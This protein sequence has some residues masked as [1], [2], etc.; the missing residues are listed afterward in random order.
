[1]SYNIFEENEKGSYTP[2]FFLMKLSFPF[3][4]RNLSDLP[5]ENLGTF[6]HEYV[7]YLQNTSTPYGLWQAII[8]YKAI[9]E[10]FSFVQKNKPSELPVKNYSPSDEMKRLYDLENE[11]SGFRGFIDIP[12][13]QTL[14][15]IHD[16]INV[17]QKNIDRITLVFE[18]AHGI[19]QEIILGANIIKESM[20]A[21][22]QE[23]IHPQSQSNHLAMPYHI[24]K[25]IASQISPNIEGDT[26]KL[27]ALCFISL[28]TLN[29]GK[30]LKDYMVYANANQDKDIIAIF[31]HFVENSIVHT[32]KGHDIS[33]NQLSDEIVE[34]YKHVAQIFLFG[35]N[36][37]IK[38]N[39]LAEIV[40]RCKIS[41]GMIPLLRLLTEHDISAELLQSAVE[42]CGTPVI[43]NEFGNISI[44][45]AVGQEKPDME[46]WALIAN[47][48]LYKRMSY[49]KQY[50]CP[51]YPICQNCI[52]DNIKDECYELP[53][54]GKKCTMTVIGHSLGLK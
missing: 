49:E 19:T 43:W 32:N 23:I 33:I 35:N 30:T 3:N 1:M 25:R 18:D 44:P 8:Y 24:V 38:L 12:E 10:F 5:I 20:A 52:K 27:I 54:K 39:Y 37:D 11:A 51:M 17:H 21:M 34:T 29:P 28:H 36:S 9:S 4:I 16:I 7:H 15:I 26:K 2:G 13:N 50:V 48:S 42:A 14:N 31:E 40:D 22:V 53:W 41:N 46:I 6:A 45:N 47:Q